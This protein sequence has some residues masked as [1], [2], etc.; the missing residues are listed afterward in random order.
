MEEIDILNFLLIIIHNTRAFNSLPSKKGKKWVCIALPLEIM[1]LLYYSTNSHDQESILK[2]P[3]F[4]ESNFH[5]LTEAVTLKSVALLNRKT[6]AAPS[7]AV[8]GYTLEVT[9]VLPP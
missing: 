4:A 8:V 3:I 9:H 5:I 2:G 1:H 6:R 7:I